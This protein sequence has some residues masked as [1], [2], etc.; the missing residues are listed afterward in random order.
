MSI[1]ASSHDGGKAVT[2]NSTQIII[3]P[4]TDNLRENKNIIPE[5]GLTIELVAESSANWWTLNLPCQSTDT[6]TQWSMTSSTG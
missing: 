6:A 4:T 2:F 3:T 1:K 5:T